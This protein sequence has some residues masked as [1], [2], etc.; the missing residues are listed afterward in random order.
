MYE[1][2]TKVIILFNDEFVEGTVVRPALNAYWI[3]YEGKEY[4]CPR[5]F[6]DEWNNGETAVAW[7]ISLWK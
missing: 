2:G 6:L 3:E 1:N 4:F 7:A 5:R